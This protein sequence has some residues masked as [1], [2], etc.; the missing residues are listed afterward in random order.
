MKITN[1][2]ALLLIDLQKGFEDIEHWG[3]GRNNPEAE[4]NAAEILKVWREKD[5]P[6]FHIKH[7]STIPS[8]PF[9][10]GNPGNDFL[11]LT[12]P[13]E[14]EPVIKKNV[15]SAFIGTDLKELLDEKGI[16][17][18]VIVGLTTDHCISTSTRMAGNFGYETYLISDATAAFDKIGVNGEKF[19]AQLIHDTALAS[20]HG[21]FATVVDTDEFLN[22][23]K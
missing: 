8:S 12:R 10:E 4:E 15:N 1:K 9:V 19:S 11:E 13:I 7:C 20:L 23:L 18:L 22:Y 5:L 3:G 21:E 14:S 2:T 16:T 17:K 6:L